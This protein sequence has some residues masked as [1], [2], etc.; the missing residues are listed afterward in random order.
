MTNRDREWLAIEQTIA[1]YSDERRERLPG[2][3]VGHF[4]WRECAELQKKSLRSDLVRFPLN[5]VWAIPYLAVKTIVEFAEKLGFK[6]PS[7]WFDKL[8]SG[9]KTDFQHEIEWLIAVELF[10]QPYGYR[11]RKSATDE[12]RRALESH[13]DL[14]EMKARGEIEKIL[15]SPKTLKKELDKYSAART[16]IS[17][18]VASLMTLA[19]GHV[20][21]GQGSLGA[22]GLGEKFAASWANE[23]ATSNFFLGK[24]A[25]QVYYG[26][27]PAKASSKEIFIATCMVFGI[28]F[29]TSF[30]AGVLSE[31]ARKK[32]G[33]QSAKLGAMIDEFE[34][35]LVVGCRK[36]HRQL[37]DSSDSSG[38]RPA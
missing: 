7:A 30:I 6:K 22:T 35:A 12:L 34:S 3:V 16:L 8:P 14:E 15:P 37:R 32:L 28:L 36:R 19:M 9:F 25:G 24:S 17:D 11:K 26:L 27:F 2:F 29:V 4:E 13:P 21:F 10:G 5:A 33:L 20:F 18:S 38:R 1:R 31:P 23:R